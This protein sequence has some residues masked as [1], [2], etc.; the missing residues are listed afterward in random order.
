VACGASSLVSA[1]IILSLKRAI[2]EAL[3]EAYWQ[4]CHVHF[5]RNAL[6]YLPRKVADDC[7]IELRCL[8]DRRNA[9]EAHGDLTA[10]LLR[11][12]E[13]IRASVGGSKR[14]LKKR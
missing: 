13:S 14:T 12:Q 7:L 1:T 8:Y 9:E 4:R 5:L 11:W 3:S 10:W 6:D 2:I